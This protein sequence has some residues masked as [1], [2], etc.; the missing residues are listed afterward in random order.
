MFVPKQKFCRIIFDT[1]TK[2][3]KKGAKTLS[4]GY[5]TKNFYSSPNMKSRLAKLVRRPAGACV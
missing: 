2:N 1:S 4:S 5:G 3:L